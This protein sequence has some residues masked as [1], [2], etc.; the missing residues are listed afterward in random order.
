MEISFR[1]EDTH[2]VVFCHGEW[3]PTAVTEM[4]M[5]I[6]D[7]ATQTSHFQILLNWFNVSAPSTEFHRFLAGKDAVKILPHSFRLAVLYPEELI[8]KFAENT[9][10]NRGACFLVCHK[11][12]EA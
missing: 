9:T 6:V 2:L 5:H 3:E 10:V 8:N 4:L 1:E 7:R 11:E 12:E